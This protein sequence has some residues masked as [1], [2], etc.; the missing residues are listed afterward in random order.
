MVF[1]QYY[2]MLLFAALQ[3]VEMVQQI[4]FSLQETDQ[5]YQSNLRNHK[6]TGQRRRT[7][8]VDA[9]LIFFI[10]LKTNKNK[11]R[12]IVLWND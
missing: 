7:N 3:V 5:T 10:P 1:P 6:G 9:K 4:L 2:G 8:Q 12:N 11:Q